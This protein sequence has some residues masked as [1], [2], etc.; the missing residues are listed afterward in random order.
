MTITEL[1][2]TREAMSRLDLAG[3]EY[4]RGGALAGEPD[5]MF[6]RCGVSWCVELKCGKG[7]L[8]DHQADYLHGCAAS[9]QV[10][11]VVTWE[12]TRGDWDDDQQV[13]ALWAL[14]D[15]QPPSPVLR[16]GLVEDL[17]RHVFYH[18]KGK[19]PADALKRALR[20]ALMSAPMPPRW[21]M[22][23]FW[24]NYRRLTGEGLS[25]LAIDTAALFR[26]VVGWEHV[27][28]HTYRPDA[29]L[30][31]KVPA[32]RKEPQDP[33]AP[34]YVLLH[35][36]TLDDKPRGDSWCI[37]NAGRIGF[38][39]GAWLLEEGIYDSIGQMWEPF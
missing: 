24:A 11:W 9:G 29:I 5:L 33:T 6:N 32:F 26:R 36:S 18:R 4:R 13:Q 19:M 21:W 31:F 14:I 22:P 27:H 15:G 2:L 35:M 39:V 12:D 10:P 20:A 30:T 37:G 25:W 16:R 1:D 34:D 17:P 3:V 28:Y 23:F 38:D 7:K 8:Q